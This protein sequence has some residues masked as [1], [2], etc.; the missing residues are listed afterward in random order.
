MVWDRDPSSFY[1]L[2]MSG[3]FSTICWRAYS[4][5]NCLGTYVDHQVTIF[6]QSL[7]SFLFVCFCI[8]PLLIL[9]LSRTGLSSFCT[10]CTARSPGGHSRPLGGSTCPHANLPVSARS[11][12]QMLCRAPAA[13]GRMLWTSACTFSHL[14]WPPQTSSFPSPKSMRSCPFSPAHLPGQN[15]C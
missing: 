9:W 12:L 7:L 8:H 4:F 11:R 2:W 13:H 1:C 5:P 14:V 6:G 10:S 3:C 15:L